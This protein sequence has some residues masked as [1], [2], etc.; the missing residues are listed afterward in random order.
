MLGTI[1]KF[2]KLKTRFPIAI[3]EL[4][5]EEAIHRGYRTGDP[6]SDPN[7]AADPLFGYDEQLLQRSWLESR[8]REAGI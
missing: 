8:Q 5:R 6:G 1:T 7:V 2:G 3:F 4:G